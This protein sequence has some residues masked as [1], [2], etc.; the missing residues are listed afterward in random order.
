MYIPELVVIGERCLWNTEN[1]FVRIS[2]LK[3]NNSSKSL[4]YMMVRK[5]LY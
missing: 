1:S 5:L 4:N 3:S 2:N